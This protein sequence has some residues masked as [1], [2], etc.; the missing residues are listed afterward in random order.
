MSERMSNSRMTPCADQTRARGFTL[1]EVMI[2][3]VV[4]A[5]GV[6]GVIG[7]QTQTYKQLQ[8]SQNFSKA[9]LLAGGMADRMLT[10]Q[11]QVLAVA[12]VHDEAPSD[13]PVPNCANAACDP[14]QLAA[15]DVWH[16]Q[17]ELRGKNPDDGTK[18]PGSLPTAN[19]QVYTDAGE[20]IILVRWDDDLDGDAGEE[21]AALDPDSAQG[22]DDLDCYALNLGCLDALDAE[23]P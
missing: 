19:G 14:T 6:M 12:Y 4:P 8:T 23:C 17:A 11:G 1:L 16:W 5:I 13:E 20:Y 21:C 7:L 3:L 9:T 2:S 18:V 15:Y 10:N 22:L